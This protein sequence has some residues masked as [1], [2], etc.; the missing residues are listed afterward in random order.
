[1]HEHVLRTAHQ[2]EAGD[3]AKT[4][5]A[6]SAEGLDALEETVVNVAVLP[7]GRV[8]AWFYL[9]QA[10]GSLRFDDHRGLEL[11]SLQRSQEGL[12]GGLTRSATHGP[13]RGA[14]CT[15]ANLDRGCW[16]TEP[17]PTALAADGSQKE[18]VY[19]TKRQLRRHPK[20]GAV[21]R[22]VTCGNGS[23]PPQSQ[24]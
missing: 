16:L 24:P 13:D 10:W 22:R 15:S 7:F 12:S 19:L 11:A 6:T 8:Y 5:A 21:L 14:E 4:S 20:S 9:T 1:M 23:S 18:K 2:D 3:S 17:R